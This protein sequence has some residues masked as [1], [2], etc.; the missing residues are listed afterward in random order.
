MLWHLHS[1]DFTKQLQEVERVYLSGLIQSHDAQEGIRAF[2][3]KRQPAWKG[4]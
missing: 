3:E 1:A 2:L 4:R